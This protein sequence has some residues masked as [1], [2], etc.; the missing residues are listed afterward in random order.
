MRNDQL[1]GLL[2]TI[3]SSIVRMLGQIKQVVQ[4]PTLTDAE[5]IGQVCYLLSTHNEPAAVIALRQE[6]NAGRGDNGY[7]AILERRSLEL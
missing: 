3:G 5:K 4:D 2:D 7:H 1:A 6:L